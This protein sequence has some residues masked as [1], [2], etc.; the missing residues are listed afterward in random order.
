MLTRTHGRV[1]L[2]QFEHFQ[3]KG[4]ARDNRQRE[5]FQLEGVA[6]LRLSAKSLGDQSTWLYI[7][8]VINKFHKEVSR[9]P[10]SS[11]IELFS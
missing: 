6:R 3:D 8:I 4:R 10:N 9:Q 7:I 11:W 2:N 1:F 5:G